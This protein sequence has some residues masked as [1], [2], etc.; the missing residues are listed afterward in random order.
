MRFMLAGILAL[1]IPF[2]GTAQ[3][4]QSSPTGWIKEAVGNLNITQVSFSNWTQGGENT[5]AWQIIVNTKFSRKGEKLNW[6]TSGKFSF[7]KA[8]LGKS[9]FRKSVDEIK[10]ESVLTY[11]LGK[12][13]NPFLAA[14]ML[15]QFTD[16]FVYTDTSRTKISD[17]LDPG[18]FTQSVGLA[19]APFSTMKIRLGFAFKETVTRNFPAHYAD[20]PATP[21][22][23]TI[24]FEVGMNSAMELSQKLSETVRL[25]SK[26]ALFSNLKSIKEV[27]VNW[28]SLISA[29]ISRL[30]NVNFNFRLIYDRNVSPK[31]QIKQS[32]AVGF[33]YTFF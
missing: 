20:D 25:E 10:L 28:D 1:L 5:F 6:T 15:T 2:T 8:K 9:Q 30:V 17:F 19:A 13:V 26:L 3:E 23:E 22:L 7:G 4:T 12:H 31:R 29:S 16:G 11:R 32:L 14:T 18:Y 33:T 24:R 27:D 21:E